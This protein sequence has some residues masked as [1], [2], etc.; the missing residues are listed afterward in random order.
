MAGFR[1]DV[2]H[3]ADID[4]ISIVPLLKDTHAALKR[5]ALYCHYPHNYP[6]TSPVSA[7]RAGDWKLIEFFENRHLEMYNIKNY[8]A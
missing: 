8:C 1:G 3:N 6:T 5:E 7:V 4:G 2:R